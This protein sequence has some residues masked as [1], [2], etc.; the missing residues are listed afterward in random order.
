MNIKIEKKGFVKEGKGN[1]KGLY[2]LIQ[3]DSVNTGGYLVL[4]NQSS[5]M[6]SPIGSDDWVENLE[7]L[8]GYINE[9]GLVIEWLE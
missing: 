7:A 8:E 5:D 6:T 4:Y 1:R 9:L 3:D 2:V